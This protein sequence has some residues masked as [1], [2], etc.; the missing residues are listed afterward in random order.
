[1]TIQVDLRVTAYVCCFAQTARTVVGKPRRVVLCGGTDKDLEVLDATRDDT[2]KEKLE[3]E[4]DISGI[5]L[6]QRPPNASFTVSLASICV[7][8]ALRSSFNLFSVVKLSAIWNAQNS[9]Y[10]S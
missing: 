1:M 9:N 2:Q 3:R 8:S 5:R 7:G 6:N 10:D 4:L